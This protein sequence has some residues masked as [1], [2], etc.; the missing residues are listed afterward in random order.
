MSFS[1]T[2]KCIGVIA[3]VAVLGSIVARADIGNTI[4]NAKTGTTVS[5]SGT[6]S[7]AEEVKV[8]ASVTVQGSATF[9]FTT[10]S[11]TTAGLYLTAS[12]AKIQQHHGYRRE[13]RHRRPGGQLLGHFLQGPQQLQYGHHLRKQRREELTLFRVAPRMTMLTRKA[14]AVMPTVSA[15]NRARARASSSAI[16]PPIATLT[17]DT[18]SRNRAILWS[19]AAWCPTAKVP[20]VGTK[21]MATESRWASVAIMWPIRTPVASPTT[22]PPATRRTDSAPTAML[23]RST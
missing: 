5:C 15:A 10:G 4:N 8:P 1:K 17:T 23:A 20:M 3:A 7:V 21:A 11:K 13:S 2:Q 6:Y 12:G 19:P 14:A 22:I 9:N 18:T 16:A